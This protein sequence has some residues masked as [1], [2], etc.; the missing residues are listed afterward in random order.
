[1]NFIL[2]KNKYALIDIKTKEKQT[3]FNSLEK[4]NYLNNGKPLAQRLVRRFKKQYKN[5]FSNL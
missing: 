2:F 1:M 4:C 5:I 3:Y